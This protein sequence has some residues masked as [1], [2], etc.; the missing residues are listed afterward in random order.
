MNQPAGSEC[1]PADL[2]QCPPQD[3]LSCIGRSGRANERSRLDQI[4]FFKNALAGDL[5]AAKHRRP[6]P[7]RQS[8]RPNAPRVDDMTTGFHTRRGFTDVRFGR[9]MCRPNQSSFQLELSAQTTPFSERPP[10]R[11]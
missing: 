6:R 7:N 2:A 10:M 9:S 4:V 11:Q 1:R 8:I 5:V 3:L